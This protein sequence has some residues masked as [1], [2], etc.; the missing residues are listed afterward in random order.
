MMHVKWMV[1]LINKQKICCMQL[2]IQNLFID[3]KAK[4]TLLCEE[5]LYSGLEDAHL[6][7]MSQ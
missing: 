1:C 5:E 2:Q 4:L 6:A 7:W 3:V